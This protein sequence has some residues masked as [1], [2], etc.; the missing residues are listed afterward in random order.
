MSD[1]SDSEA[2]DDTTVVGSTR[3]PPTPEQVRHSL[4]AS[5]AGSRSLPRAGACHFS[6]TPW[7][8]SRQRRAS[9]GDA[10][11]RRS[12]RRLR[13][14]PARRHASGVMHPGCRR[15]ALG[16]M[17]RA[18]RPWRVH[19]RCGRVGCGGDVRG[20]RGVAGRVGARG[21][22]TDC[23]VG[24]DQNGGKQKVPSEP[25]Q[26]GHRA[27][28]G[29]NRAQSHEPHPLCKPCLLPYKARKLWYTP[30]FAPRQRLTSLRS[31]MAP[32]CMRPTA[33]V[34]M[35]PRARALRLHVCKYVLRRATAMS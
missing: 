26:R 9:P 24:G 19:T 18:S 15:D 22:C 13:A 1:K 23:Q 25:S 28:Y 21:C 7:H 27:L 5:P 2:S 32:A 16:A 14:A 4:G 3:S 17:A 35:R 12:L 31:L 29:S 11:A 6:R 33:R 20:M 8:A 10:P 30:P 34:R